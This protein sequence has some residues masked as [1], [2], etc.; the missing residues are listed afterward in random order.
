[1]AGQRNVAN[2]TTNSGTMQMRR[3]WLSSVD[4]TKTRIKM[5]SPEN[6]I[7]GLL[8]LAET[9]VLTS[10]CALLAGA[11]PDRHTGEQYAGNSS[12]LMH[13]SK[14]QLSQV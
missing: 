1:M 4:C 10:T 14:L 9:A 13:G 2:V 7:K 11:H 8:R 6:Q 3:H 5:S 12:R